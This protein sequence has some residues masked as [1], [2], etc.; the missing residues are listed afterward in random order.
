MRHSPRARPASAALV[1]APACLLLLTPDP[2]AAS[3]SEE[4]GVGGVTVC[5]VNGGTTSQVFSPGSVIILRQ[6][7]PGVPGAGLIEEN[8]EASDAARAAALVKSGRAAGQTV[9]TLGSDAR[10][11]RLALFFEPFLYDKDQSATDRETA[12]D[13]EGWGA[14]AG[15]SLQGEAW[16]ASLALDY[17][18]EQVDYAAGAFGEF[19]A[20]SDD[21]LT[22]ALPLPGAEAE[23]DDYGASLGAA[24]A[25]SPRITAFAGG[26]FGLIDLETQRG[27]ISL[28]SV[29]DPSSPDP[30]DNVA[31]TF[32]GAGDT[33][34]WSASLG[35][36]AQYAAPLQ[37]GLGL[38]GAASA[39]LVWLYESFDGYTERQSDGM[40]TYTFEDDDRR[41]V[42]S[43]VGV[44]L[45]RPFPFAGGAF[46]PF[47][48]AAWLHEYADDSRTVGVR[49]EIL[50]NDF[51]EPS[52]FT[53]RTNRPDRNFFRL[54][55][56]VGAAT[57]DGRAQAALVYETLVGHDYLDIQSLRLRLGL[58]F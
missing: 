17:G 7:V 20:L 5:G 51:D 44:T 41:S 49:S 52:D 33:D 4:P 10:R 34:G 18:R 3:C 24:Y 28:V 25:V 40:P 14:A 46:A 9:V 58:Q 8:D 43:E 6:D 42:L 16:S 47:A 54:G 2:A 48:S 1:T 26:R 36:G 15:L 45:S 11:V 53:I 19:T 31:E 56:G 23:R 21:S 38:F 29:D 39:Q 57:A 50:L 37:L 27:V 12:Y 55:A 13:G 30:Q 35:A 22:F 32:H